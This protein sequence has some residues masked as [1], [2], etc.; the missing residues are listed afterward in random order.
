[1]EL[2]SSPYSVLIVMLPLIPRQQEKERVL[3]PG[4]GSFSSLVPYP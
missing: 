4:T 3:V 1:M 2:M